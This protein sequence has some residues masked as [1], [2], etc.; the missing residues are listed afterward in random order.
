MNQKK[1]KSSRKK[2]D[3]IDIKIFNLI[4]KRTSVVKYMLN[5]K[6]F[7]SQIVDRKRTNE[8]L[9]N[10][11]KKSIKNSVDPKI[12]ARIWKSIIWGYVDFQRRNFKKK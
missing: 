11:K 4:K 10:I 5:L 8:I 3:Q 12:T 9:R 6:K 2:I 1:L 7:K